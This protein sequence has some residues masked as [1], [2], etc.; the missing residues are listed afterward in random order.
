[1]D[2]ENVAYVHFHLPIE[3]VLKVV[4]DDQTA[5]ELTESKWHDSSLRPVKR[6]NHPP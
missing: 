4:F 2:V 1:M 3:A 6:E 5:T